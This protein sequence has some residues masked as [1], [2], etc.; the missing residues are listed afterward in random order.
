MI[1]FEIVCYPNLYFIR[2]MIILNF[3]ANLT[4][5]EKKLSM[6]TAKIITLKI[7]Y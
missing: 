7:L 2:I 1:K 6:K 4:F 3:F 5:M